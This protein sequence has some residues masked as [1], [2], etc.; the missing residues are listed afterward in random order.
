M[1]LQKNNIICIIYFG[2]NMDLSLDY[3]NELKNLPEFKRLIELKQ[4]IDTKYKNEIIAFK[5][6]ESLYLESLKNDYYLGKDKIKKDFI[7]AKSNLYKKEEVKEYFDIQNKL[8][9]ILKND[10][11]EIRENISIELSKKYNCN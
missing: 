5:T 11:I 10:F 4:I 7:L 1:P 3:F 9:L 2:D 6:K 8:D